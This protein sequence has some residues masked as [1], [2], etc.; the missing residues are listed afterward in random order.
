MRESEIVDARFHML[1]Y[2][3]FTTVS[4]TN[5]RTILTIAI[6]LDRPL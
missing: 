5:N 4:I 3:S 1:I 6:K 2:D